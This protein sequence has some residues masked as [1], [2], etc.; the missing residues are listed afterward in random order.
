MGACLL[1]GSSM[2][3]LFSS[4]LGAHGLYICYKSLQRSLGDTGSQ[5]EKAT[6][7]KAVTLLEPDILTLEL[8]T[9]WRAPE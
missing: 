4:A 5:D 7:Q 2:S 9:E 1:P 3:W 8:L 6:A